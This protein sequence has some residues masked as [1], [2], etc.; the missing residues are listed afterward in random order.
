MSKI[1]VIDIGSNSV[2]LMV[3]S[4]G[5][6]LYK[7]VNTTR[8][9][10]GLSASGKLLPA[11]IARTAAA[12]KDF[13]AEADNAGCVKIAA[14]ATAAVRSA[15]NGGE[16]VKTVGAECPLK[17]DV[18]SGKAE[19]E[20]GLIGAAGYSDGG[21]LDVGGASSELTFRLNGKIGY[22]HSADIGAVRL[23]DMCGRDCGLLLKAINSAV[24]AFGD[25]KVPVP[26][27]GVGGTA[28]SLAAV[29]NNLREYSPAV[30]EGTEISA[31]EAEETGR[32]LLLT[33]V[34]EI[35]EKYPCV[36]YARAEILG[37]GALLISAVL[38]AAG[39]NKITVS[40]RDN[41]EG[42][43]ITRGLI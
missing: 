9:G 39:V 18:I 13:Y 31:D 25:V 26:V 10:E 23:F 3:M 32:K 8:L 33:P 36:P 4:N 34:K 7:R 22:S 21:I 16:F 30:V 19:A 43:A 5:K 24:R 42:Y 29:K 27:Y 20:I 17:V 1:A 38:R 35:T 14:F 15:S 11:A 2:R 12:V 37:G 28:T 40:E 6:T 41:L